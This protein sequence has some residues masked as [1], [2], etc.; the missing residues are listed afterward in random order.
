MS[1]I[2][3]YSLNRFSLIDELN[4]ETPICVIEEI[5]KCIG[6]DVSE[7]DII[8]NKNDVIE[9]ITKIKYEIEIKDKYDEEEMGRISTFVSQTETNWKTENLIRAFEHLRNFNDTI[10]ED[11]TPGPKSNN[12]PQAYDCTMLYSYCISRGIRTNKNDS[13][14]ELTAYARLTFADRK[15]LLDTL[16]PKISNIDNGEIINLIRASKNFKTKVFAMSKT[17]V[18]EI[19][20]IKSNENILN[21]CLLTDEEAII[22]SVKKYNLDISESE[23]PSSEIIHLSKSKNYKPL[24]ENSM[25]HKNYIINE[26]FYDL[27]RFWKPSLS[28]LYSENML[29]KLLNTECVN[30]NDISNPKE[31]IHELS[32]TKNF[33]PGIL[34]SISYTDTYIYKTS[35]S[36]VDPK[37]IISYGVLCT[38]E[39]IA[40][41]ID[42]I[43]DFFNSHKDFRDFRSEGELISERNIKKLI[44]ICRRHPN[45][46]SFNGLLSVIN[47]TKELSSII[48]SKIKEFLTYHKNV[49]FGN[50]EKILMFFKNLFHLSMFMRGWKTIISDEYP[51]TVEQTKGYAE[52]YSEIEIKVSNGIKELI[53]NF[54][55]LSDGSKMLIRCL[56]L[57]KV[58]EK[59]NSFYKS[60][61]EDEGLTFMKR[62]EILQKSPESVYACL[63]MSSNHLASTSQYYYM[64]LTGKTLFDISKLS[65]IS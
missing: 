15:I 38:K 25:F 20:K 9:Y 23:K 30:Y 18:S 19:E 6:M 24:D 53:E 5:M 61:N 52:K 48:N 41:T 55:N 4:D 35:L 28:C 7:D 32:L 46:I 56:P 65:L 17:S 26:E 60:T 45:D 21:R 37:Y 51:L 36:E 58:N 2:S 14:K 42:E 16:I 13:L 34:P 10:P 44:M 31:F 3:K 49:D 11:F 8:L 22:Q 50:Q 63:R 40:L 62:I 1:T 29:M 39:L 43:K 57:I 64:S 12:S 33:Y 47:K 54:N 27:T 59:D